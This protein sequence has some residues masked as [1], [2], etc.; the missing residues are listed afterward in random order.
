MKRQVTHKTSL[1]RLLVR[2]VPRY[3]LTAQREHFKALGLSGE[4]VEFDAAKAKERDDWY[5]LARPGDTLAVGRI[6]L[7]PDP[8]RKGAG[9]QPTVQLG[10]I[11]PEI[12]RQYLVIEISTGIRSDSREWADAC[13]KAFAA[14]RTGRRLTSK[15]AAEI[16]AGPNA[17]RSRESLVN[18][19]KEPAQLRLRAEIGA[20]WRDTVAYP[21]YDA[22]L[23][24]VNLALADRQIPPIGSKDN[25]LRIFDG[26][27]GKRR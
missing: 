22:A 20:I 13:A 23:D 10:R 11:L 12:S 3:R 1:I 26:R 24:A 21:N 5:N 17:K 27:R 2:D 19:W 16:S 4:V 14:I 25:A 7:I 8:R 15:R 9:A 18:W 6:E